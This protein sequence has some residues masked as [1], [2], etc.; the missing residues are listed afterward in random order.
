MK[1][2]QMQKYCT[3][4]Y[5][6]GLDFTNDLTKARLKI[7]NKSESKDPLKWFL[8]TVAKMC[9]ERDIIWNI[10][11]LS[12]VLLFIL[13]PHVLSKWVG[14]VALSCVPI[15]HRFLSLL[16]WS[17]A[18][19][20]LGHLWT[21]HLSR[22]CTRRQLHKRNSWPRRANRKLLINQKTPLHWTSAQNFIMAKF[23]FQIRHNS[24][25]KTNSTPCVLHFP[26][27]LEAR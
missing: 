19:R 16:A 18:S 17:S 2:H 21:A 23:S 26:P 14:V 1:Y 20:C 12:V 13:H 10:I 9:F 27:F 8:K 4:I 6:T 11:Y 15:G 25:P 22:L 7:T 3:V 24:L 5:N